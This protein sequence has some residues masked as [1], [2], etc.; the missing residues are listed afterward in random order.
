MK[1]YKNLSMEDDEAILNYIIKGS[2]AVIEL[3]SL[4][5]KISDVDVCANLLRSV[6]GKFDSITSS[7]EQFEDLDATN[8]QD[9][10]GT[11]EY[12]KT[13]SSKGQ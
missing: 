6:L 13:S 11:L 5:E 12:M 1:D 10:V 4:G 2:L 9:V 7:M 3:R 8:L